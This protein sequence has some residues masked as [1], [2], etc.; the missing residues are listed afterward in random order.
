M[1]R[2]SGVSRS[3]DR[4][5]GNGIGNGSLGDSETELREMELGE[6]G[7]PRRK[8]ASHEVEEVLGGRSESIV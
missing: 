3:R 4:R 2:W 7:T 6:V 1:R 8:G 5:V